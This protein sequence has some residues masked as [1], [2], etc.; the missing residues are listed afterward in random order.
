M[1]I[2]LYIY[3]YNIVYK[4]LNFSSSFKIHLLHLFLTR[5]KIYDKNKVILKAVDKG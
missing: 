1:Y 2:I 3:I 4:K 5:N